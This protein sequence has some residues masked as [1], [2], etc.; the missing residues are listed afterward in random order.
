MVSGAPNESDF[1]SAT[2]KLNLRF[3][4]GL[5]YG[6]PQE[7]IIVKQDEASPTPPGPQTLIWTLKNLSTVYDTYGNWGTSK[8]LIDS[9][10]GDMHAQE[11]DE[12]YEASDVPFYITSWGGSV[13]RSAGGSVTIN[14][15]YIKNQTRPSAGTIVVYNDSSGGFIG[16]GSINVQNGDTII[17]TDFA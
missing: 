11:V 4:N 6:V 13:S 9:I 3:G 16:E 12:H 1:R 10:Q 8:T 15:F 14:G 17:M 2:A 7:S 5:V